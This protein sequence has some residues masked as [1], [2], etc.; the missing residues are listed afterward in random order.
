[1]HFEYRS[2]TT[3]LLGEWRKIWPGLR[4]EIDALVL[5]AFRLLVYRLDQRG[6]F[7]IPRQVQK[8]LMASL[9]PEELP[10]DL[11]IFLK[12]RESKHTPEFVKVFAGKVDDRLASD[13]LHSMAILA[14][15]IDATFGATLSD[16]LNKR[17]HDTRQGVAKAVNAAN[18][19]LMGEPGT[20]R[21]MILVRSSQRYWSG[22][23]GVVPEFL[24]RLQATA[25]NFKYLLPV[26]TQ[27]SRVDYSA[28][29]SGCG[30]KLTV[31]LLPA[32]AP[33]P[34]KVPLSDIQ[35]ITTDVAENGI[36]LFRF[37]PWEDLSPEL[38]KPHTELAD[39]I[40]RYVRD[41]PDVSD[42]VHIV[43]APELILAPQSHDSI[44]EAIASRKNAAWIVFPGTYHLERGKA[45]V[46]QAPIYV[47]GVL[48][49]ADL[50]SPVSAV[51]RTA[52]KFVI[53]GS[54]GEYV[55]DLDGSVCSVH[56]VD[57]NAGRI[58]VMIC[59]DYLVPDIRSEVVS[60]GTDH[61]FILAMSDE[62]GGKFK[63][64][65]EIASDFRTGSYLVNA[66]TKTSWHAE[67]RK[68]L[69][70]T[71]ANSAGDEQ[72]CVRILEPE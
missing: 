55:E 27:L 21:P 59:L 20:H 57:S 54:A 16:Y 23:K 33:L 28:F 64:A 30:P 13:D 38:Q 49:Q 24:G 7:L 6:F 10:A 25:S 9:R 41:T 3:D 50:T 69:K 32:K 4:D 36:E 11:T 72:P 46:N 47:G 67:Y 29:G 37:K 52:F 62:T 56:L 1:M 22:K 39:R 68:P 12:A 70:D 34:A 14:F 53:P 15:A 63:R 35:A 8:A 71:R 19:V 45:V 44:I 26:T 65:R 61:L 31:A 66:F 60:M 58:A 5:V 18:R 48:K 51:K 40:A 2:V 42:T 43:A 17:W